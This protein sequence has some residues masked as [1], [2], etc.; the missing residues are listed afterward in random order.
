LFTCSC[1][2]FHGNDFVQGTVVAVK[3]LQMSADADLQ[4]RVLL[5]STEEI[6]IDR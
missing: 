4:E 3:E 1:F 5:L 2:S 6:E